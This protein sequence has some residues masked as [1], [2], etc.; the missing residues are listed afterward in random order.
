MQYFLAVGRASKGDPECRTP[1]GI[2]EPN[3]TAEEV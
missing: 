3:F 2:N 1:A